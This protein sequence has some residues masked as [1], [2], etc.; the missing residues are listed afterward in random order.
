M[1]A[2]G[3]LTSGWPAKL[4]IIPIENP[5]NPE[6]NLNGKAEATYSW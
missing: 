3:P 5:S 1:K 2:S 6:R 4:H